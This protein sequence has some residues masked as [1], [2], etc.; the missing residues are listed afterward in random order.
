MLIRDCGGGEGAGGGDRKLGSRSQKRSPPAGLRPQEQVKGTDTG[1]LLP[2]SSGGHLK[3]RGTKIGHIF[4]ETSGHIRFLTR[5][6][7]PN[8]RCG[9]V[10]TSY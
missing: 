1:C 8:L 3:D 6:F 9:P 2:S 7:P 4:I 5:S 10:F